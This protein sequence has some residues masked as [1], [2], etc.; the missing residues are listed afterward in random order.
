MKP[1]IVVHHHEIGLKGKNRSYFEKHLLRNVRL[2]LR[3]LLPQNNITGGYG[4]FIIYLTEKNQEEII[5]RLKKI[6]GLSNICF[7]FET[8]QSIEKFIQVAKILLKDKS[9]NTIKVHAS[10]AD[11]NFPLNSMQINS[12]VGKFLCDR[13][14]VRANLSQPDITIYIELANKLAYI[15]LSKIEGAGGLPAGI[16]GRVVSLIS[17]GFDSPVAS[18][19]LMKRGAYIIFVHFHSYPYVSNSSIEQVQSIVKKLT[20]YQFYSKL[21][22]VPFA[23]CQKEIVLK[24]DQKLRVILYRRMMIRVAE[25]IAE[26]EKANALVTGEALGQ[27]ASQTLQNIKVIDAVSNLPILR[28]LIGSDK[29]EIIKVANLIGTYEIS[30]EPYDDCCSFLNPK[31]P[32]T[33]A[34]YNEVLNAE[35]NLN[36]DEMLK[37]LIES[38]EKKEFK[39]P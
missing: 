38:L 17:A 31:N 10:R 3:D 9:F 1:I 14:K 26:M 32:E 22:L 16:S 33:W 5:E 8:E 35:K 15:Y 23:E 37:S 30:K 7:G 34:D 6:F 2:A 29:E 27:V 18:Y 24:T 4:R 25:K 20:S 13:F 39:Y 36:I 21:Y 19:K 11:K 12:E 28:P